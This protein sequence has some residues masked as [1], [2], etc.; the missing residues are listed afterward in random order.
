MRTSCH[1]QSHYRFEPAQCHALH[2][3]FILKR[4]CHRYALN[5]LPGIIYLIMKLTQVLCVDLHS[6]VICT[7]Y[8]IMKLTIAVCGPAQ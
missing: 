6:D 8:F 7:L 1:P 4:T 2:T 5:T 3:L